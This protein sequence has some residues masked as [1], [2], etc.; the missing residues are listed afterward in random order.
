MPIKRSKMDA[1]ATVEM[2]DAAGVGTGSQRIINNRFKNHFGWRFCAT[3]LEVIPLKDRTLTPKLG[4]CKY[5]GD[6]N[7][8]FW[9]KDMDAVVNNHIDAY[10]QHKKMMMKKFTRMFRALILL[11]EATMVKDLFER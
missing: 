8:T 7:T 3:E 4:T 1:A 10:L 5:D 6:S 9:Y 2:W 11:L